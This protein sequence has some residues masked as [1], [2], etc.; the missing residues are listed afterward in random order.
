MESLSLPSSVINKSNPA[1]C[2]N[3]KVQRHFEMGNRLEG[4]V[5]CID[6]TLIL[7]GSKNLRI[8]FL[9]G[10]LS[11]IQAQDYAN[12]NTRS[13]VDQ[14]PIINSRSGTSVYA[15]GKQTILTDHSVHS[16]L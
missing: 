14:I 7:S 12:R 2:K 6:E 1:M 13:T 3:F 16:E 4:P 9:R 8:K 10:S 5:G 11:F 15:Y